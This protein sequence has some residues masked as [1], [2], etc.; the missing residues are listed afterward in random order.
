M[1]IISSANSLQMVI[2]QP[3]TITP[4]QALI[5]HISFIVISPE[6]PPLASQSQSDCHFIK[7]GMYDLH[8]LTAITYRDLMSRHFELNR[9]DHAHYPWSPTP[10]IATEAPT[11]LTFDR[12]SFKLKTL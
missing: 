7:H 11:S 2:G 10:P 12:L 3:G 6:R 1:P 5:Q 4:L 9:L 8:A